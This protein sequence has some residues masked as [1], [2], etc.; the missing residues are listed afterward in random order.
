MN[1]LFA[2]CAFAIPVIVSIYSFPDAAIAYL[3]CLPFVLA[4][5]FSIKRIDG[6]REFLTKL[7]I[8]AFLVR[9]I[10]A[11]L[12]PAFDLQIFFG[13]DAIAHEFHGLQL[14]RYW[15]GLITYPVQLNDWNR[16]WGLHLLIASV[17]S[18][19]GRNPLAISFI[20]SMLGSLTAVF[21]YLCTITI[22]RNKYAGRAAAL[23]VAFFP[24]MIIWSAQIL[25]DGFVV[26]FVVL[27]IYA[28]IR[29]QDQF[30]WRHFCVLAFALV[31]VFSIRF[32][33][34]YFA[35]FATVCTFVFGSQRV[36][37]N[38]IRWLL[39]LGVVTIIAA[40][41]GVMTVGR[42]QVERMSN[43]ESIQYSR[44]SL[45][46]EAASGYGSDTDIRT[47]S[48]AAIALPLGLANLIMAPF[49]WQFSSIRSLLTLP[50]MIVWWALI[51]ALFVG[52]KFT[53]RNKFRAAIP[54][55]LFTVTLTAAYALFQTNVGTAY[56]QRTQI[57]VFLF[58]FMAAG[59]T[60][61]KERRE[62]ARLLANNRIQ[63]FE[64]SLINRN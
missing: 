30:D 36:V 40:Y 1:Q 32:Y 41:S 19:I 6:D 31:A 13:E 15:G 38:N 64:H 48:G 59:L 50:E 2:F 16:P 33:I 23:M 62:D 29:L 21:I 28:L 49:P 55:I 4:V 22:F 44:S 20:S 11:T 60:V 24:A 39:I 42:E 37:A 34:F 3:F 18:L 17:Y 26:F 5:V 61:L 52:I 12:I 27:A 43:L 25:K 56:R 10:V 46:R 53:F 47:A 35:T 9:T 58:V 54:I 7:F 51:P 45:S 14:F 8:A 63:R 57:Q